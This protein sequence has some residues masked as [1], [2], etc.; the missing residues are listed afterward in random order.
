MVRKTISLRWSTT[1]LFLE[2]GRITVL[3]SKEVV[4]H[5]RTLG[6]VTP[7]PWTIKDY[8]PPPKQLGIA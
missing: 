7:L 5:P 2:S 1:S 8:A 6:V 4:G 3:P